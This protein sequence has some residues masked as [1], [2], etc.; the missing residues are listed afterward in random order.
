MPTT[1]L[2]GHTSL[3]NSISIETMNNT[4]SGG[5]LRGNRVTRKG[6]ETNIN[7]GAVSSEFADSNNF[8]NFKTHFNEARPFFYSGSA[9]HYPKDIG[10]CWRTEGSSE[11]RPNY[12]EAGLLSEIQMSVSSY[13][14]I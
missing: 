4:T 9:L 7:F 11:I 12:I 14:D 6:A 13:V 2:S 8:Q 5:H 3:H 10:L 1:P